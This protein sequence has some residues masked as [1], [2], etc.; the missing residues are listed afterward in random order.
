[1][2]QFRR[3]RWAAENN[4]LDHQKSIHLIQQCQPDHNGR[5]V[6]FFIKTR[7][8]APIGYLKKRFTPD[9]PVGHATALKIWLTANTLGEGVGANYEVGT[10]GELSAS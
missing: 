2:P 3:T 10:H 7:H 9:I 1:M 8:E 5:Q 6:L 4:V